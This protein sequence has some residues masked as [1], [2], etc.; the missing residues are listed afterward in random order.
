MAARL[1]QLAPA[2]AVQAL[3]AVALAVAREIEAA[4]LPTVGA[5][6][7]ARGAGRRFNELGGLLLAAHVRCACDT[8]AGLPHRGAAG[9]GLR[10][11][12][13]KLRQ[14]SRLLSMRAI[15]DVY[16][17]VEPAPAMTLDEV[18]AVLALRSDF[19][20]AALASLQVA[21]LRCHV[22]VA[23][24]VGGIGGT[25]TVSGPRSGGST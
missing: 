1:G 14:A 12:F 22:V 3:R 8:L 15:G 24:G 13:G 10:S 20:A 11:C 19:P 6:R 17:V 23:P 18:T 9:G 16:S 4:V 5:P 2:A 7:R 25:T 21:R